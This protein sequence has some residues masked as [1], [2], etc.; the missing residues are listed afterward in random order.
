MDVGLDAP[1]LRARLER[2]FLHERLG[3]TGDLVYLRGR[4]DRIVVRAERRRH[5]E[6]LL[7]RHR[8]HL[9][10]LG[11]FPFVRLVALSGACA[12]E[13][14]TDDDVDVFLV[15][16]SGRAWSVTLALMVLCKLLGVRRSLCL[17]YVV[18]EEG[19]RLPERDLFTGA[20]IVGMKPLWGRRAYRLLVS[21][22]AWVGARFPNFFRSYHESSEALPEVGCP[23]WIERLLELGPAPL[24]E[25]L[26]RVVLGAYLRRK[27]RGRPGVV[28][29][30]HRLKLHTDDHAPRLTA[31]FAEALESLTSTAAHRGEIVLHKEAG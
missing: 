21:T 31:A 2:P 7:R 1:A 26:S 10:A 27:G 3:F 6:D 13:N 28:L 15:T 23:R 18:D 9:R 24:A 4:D 19:A 11:S 20:E 8:L 22:N 16:R 17:N 25:A 5:T 14:A 30:P 29:G 12:H